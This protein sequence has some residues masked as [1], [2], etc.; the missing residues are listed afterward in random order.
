MTEPK[1]LVLTWRLP[2]ALSSPRVA[3]WRSLQRL[4]AVSLTPGAAILPYSEH[5]LEQLEWIAED[6]VQHGGDAYVLPVTELSEADEQDIERR[7][8]ADRSEEYGQLRE[9]AEALARR[10]RAKRD[11][12]RKLA[13]LER[14]LARAVERDHFKS[15]RRSAAE[16]AIRFARRREES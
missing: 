4:G 7:M 12:E 15:T 5:L 3:T 11:Y 2:S 13:V 8:R 6:I 10:A 9:A 14:G 16:R 1:W